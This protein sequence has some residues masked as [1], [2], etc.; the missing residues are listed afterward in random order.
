MSIGKY[1][2]SLLPSFD[3]GRVE[4]DLRVLKEELGQTTIPPYEAAAEYFSMEKFNAKECQQFDRLFGNRVNVERKMQGNYPVTIHHV[5]QRASETVSMLEGRVDKYF[6]RDVASSGLTYAR[7]NLLR[8]IEVTYF[9]SRYARKLLLWTYDEEKK[10]LGRQVGEPFTKAEIEWIFANRDGFFTALNVL[11]KPTK[12]IQG[13]LANIPDMIVVPEE[14]D[15][16]EQTV[17]AAKLDPLR[18]GI[19]PIKL[20]PIYHVRLAI[21]EFQVARYKAGQEEKRALEYRLLALKEIQ[22]DGGGDARLEQQIE[23][24]ENRIKKLNHRLAKMEEE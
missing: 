23:Y 3:K 22:T 24:T 21:A 14:V 1:V 15:V 2:S 5:L 11:A 7:A 13:A 10:A 17:G 4:E 19:I 6:G 12:E 16:A 8:L 18:M 20:N 9:V